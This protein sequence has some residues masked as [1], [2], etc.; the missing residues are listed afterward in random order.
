MHSSIVEQLNTYI[1]SRH[2]QFTELLRQIITIPSPTGQE[3]KKAA[4]VLKYLHDLGQ[5]QACID[6]AGN[7]LCPCQIEGQTAFPLYSAHMD[8]VF[9]SPADLTPRRAATTALASQDCCSSS[10]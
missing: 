4:W 10:P 8:T 1:R 6:E 5:G 3:G 7:V 2:S 9:E